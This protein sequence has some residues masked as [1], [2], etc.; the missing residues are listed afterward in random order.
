MKEQMTKVKEKW[1]SLGLPIKVTIG[2]AAL[3][4]LIFI[5]FKAFMP[6][7]YSTL[8]SGLD[9]SDQADIEKYL[10]SN[11]IG[12][13]IDAESG[14]IS[15]DGN[16]LEI[17]KKLALEGLPNGGTSGGLETFG[18][19]NLGSTQYDKNVQYQEALQNELNGSL[20]SMFEAV[21]SADVKLPLAEETGIWE[22]DKKN[23]SIS[24]ALKLRNGFELTPKQVKAIQVYVAGAVSNTTPDDVSVVDQ[25]LNPLSSEENEDTATTSLE[26]QQAIVNATK[27][28]LEK[29]LSD[30]LEEVYGRVKVIVNIDINFDQ[31][32]QN[33]KKYDPQGTVISSEEN[34][35]KK[36]NLTGDSASIPGT[37]ENGEVPTY[38]IS[39]ANNGDI[40]SVDEKDEIIQN[41]VVSETVEEV[42][43][44]PELR[45]INITVWFDDTKITQ[46]ALL[47]AE[48]SVAVAAG[49]KG[50]VKRVANN[51]A[52]YN[53]GSVKVT[54]KNFAKDSEDDVVKAV[55]E[56][57]EEPNKV[58]Y[59]AIG[60]AALLI[61][62]GLVVF[63]VLRSRKKQRDEERE[64]ELLESSIA[65][66]NDEIESVEE[67]GIM[68]EMEIHLGRELN[69]D[70]NSDQKSL[71]ELTNDVAMKYPK[72]TAD[73]VRRMIK[74]KK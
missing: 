60:G 41:F 14:A 63:F 49:L 65:A 57:K 13:Q 72:E 8:Y 58:L 51:K 71:R 26:K 34:K 38:E 50:E 40:L 70:W 31:I 1:S 25:D 32:A 9:E 53:N 18:G 2:T 24:V 73:V 29:E 66:K 45:T 55:K 6:D 68:K 23:V 22:D 12:Y 47:D 39:D 33:I 67:T 20:S 17:K 74:S 54:S 10:S 44:S 30:A 52:I 21:S 64:L 19:M 42:I 4:L 56:V 59:F 11:G 35:Q 46:T 15:V 69:I 62:I 3:A 61:I 27:F 7:Q 16:V 48:E 5:G 37:D 43:K 28:Q 36:Y